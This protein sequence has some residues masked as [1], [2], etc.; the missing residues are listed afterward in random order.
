MLSGSPVNFRPFRAGYWAAVTT[1]GWRPGLSACAPPGLNDDVI[2]VQTHPD[3]FCLH[4]KSG[5]RLL[6]SA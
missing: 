3:N 6:P 5:R 4:P 1:Q 2:R